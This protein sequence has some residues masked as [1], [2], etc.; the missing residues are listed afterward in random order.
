MPMSKLM[1]TTTKNCKSSL[2]HNKQKKTLRRDLL[3]LNYIRLILAVVNSNGNKSEEFES[4]FKKLN[5]NIKIELL[6]KLLKE[7]H[8]QEIR[9]F[10]TNYLKKINQKTYSLYNE[11]LNQRLK[12]ENLNDYYTQNKLRIFTNRINDEFIKISFLTKLS[13]LNSTF[14][15]SN[16]IKQPV[17]DIK[18]NKL[19][20]SIRD[21]STIL[22]SEFSLSSNALS[23]AN[24]LINYISFKIITQNRYLTEETR[25]NTKEKIQSFLSNY[26]EN[27][28][29]FN[30]FQI[31][32][33]L[34]VNPDPDIQNI[35]NDLMET[36]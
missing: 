35:A 22:L 24:Q 4:F 13:T 7:C 8:H 2:I 26:F 25:L 27:K 16:N 19:F 15:T 29:V 12:S 30:K 20:S 23:H 31:L 3:K 33:H 18:T 5:G 21:S 17:Q 6:K 34:S 32:T 9:D 1:L 14:S 10:A 11:F 36:I 28:K